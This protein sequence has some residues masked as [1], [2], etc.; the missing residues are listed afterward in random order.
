[1]S[2]RCMT[3]FKTK[4]G[5]TVPCGKCPACFARRASGWSFRLMKEYDRSLA[6]QFI[7]LTY[8]NT[9]KIHRS[10]VGKFKSLYIPHLQQFFKK[11]RRR[12]HGRDIK[13]F[14]VGEY[15]DQYQRPHY[16]VL[17]FNAEISTVQPSWDYGQIHYGKVT[18]ASVGYCLKYI[19]KPGKIPAH[20]NDDRLPETM[21]C[22]KGL[23]E[24]YITQEMI[25]WHKED[26][27]HRMYIPMPGGKKIAMP[28]YFKN[29]IYSPGERRLI[30][31]HM[32][33]TMSDEINYYTRTVVDGKIVYHEKSKNEQQKLRL[34]EYAFF[35]AIG[36]EH[37]KMVRQYQSSR[38]KLSLF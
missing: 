36:S 13:Y 34:K 38:Q 21:V 18:G 15:G 11:L 20:K 35:Q 17:L 19:S 10:P 8:G 12:N 33:I 9:D 28:R 30:N 26:L 2:T 4:D 7:T 3:P 5:Y 22:S 29:K 23:G 27:L 25:K 1:M 31:D 37:R 16:H 6:A 32:Q 14:A 24:S